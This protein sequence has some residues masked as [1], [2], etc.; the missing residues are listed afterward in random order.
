MTLGRDNNDNIEELGA[1]G[2]VL[3]HVLASVPGLFPFF[4]FVIVK[5]KGQSGEQSKE[6]DAVIMNG[7]KIAMALRYV[8]NAMMELVMDTLMNMELMPVMK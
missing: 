6:D 1:Q 8:S 5:W 4:S 3:E 2:E 7:K